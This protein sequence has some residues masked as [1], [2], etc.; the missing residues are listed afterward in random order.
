ML[1]VTLICFSICLRILRIL[2][3]FGWHIAHGNHRTPDQADH[4][5]ASWILLY[6]EPT[7]LSCALRVHSHQVQTEANEVC[8][9]VEKETKCSRKSKA[10]ECQHIL[11]VRYCFVAYSWW[12]K[13]SEKLRWFR[14]SHSSDR[15][16]KRQKQPRRLLVMTSGPSHLLWDVRSC[17]WRLI[18]QTFLPSSIASTSAQSF[19]PHN[20]DPLSHLSLQFVR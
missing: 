2:A 15:I 3:F 19:M 20:G 8:K 7:I 5:E 12:R 13:C 10:F 4:Q 11:F 1:Q 16:Y 17:E 9:T 14:Q 6:R 18:C